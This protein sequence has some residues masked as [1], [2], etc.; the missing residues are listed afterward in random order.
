MRIRVLL[1]SILANVLLIALIAMAVRWGSHARRDYNNVLNA[2]QALR[3]D[4]HEIKGARDENASENKVLNLKLSELEKVI[5]GLHAQI[6]ALKVRPS[7]AESIAE[8]GMSSNIKIKTILKDSVV[9]DTVP[10]RHFRYADDYFSIN[11]FAVRDT[12][13][14]NITYRDTLVQ[15]VFRGR[16][17]RPWLWV[18]SPRQLEQKVSLKCP[19]SHI[20]YSHLIEIQR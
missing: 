19:T 14:L 16:R 9:Y 20:N 2:N 11:G 1:I 10:V 3:E 5:P 17:K 12:Q 8:T 4:L 7:R 6:R 15:A 13:H 18:F